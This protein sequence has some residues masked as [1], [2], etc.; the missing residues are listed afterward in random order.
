MGDERMNEEKGV[1][2]FTLIYTSSSPE[3]TQELGQTLGEI[4]Q[5]GDVIC[6]FGDLGA[7][8]TCFAQG[9]AW[10]AGF[11]LHDYISSPTFTLIHEYSGKWP[12]Y[13]LDFYR[14][15]KPEE[16]LDLGYEEYFFGQGIVI[17]EWADRVDGF[18]PPERL[19]V[20][21]RRMNMMQREITITAIG[22]RYIDLMEKLV[23]EV[24]PEG[25]E[26]EQ[27]EDIPYR[28]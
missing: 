15:K 7:G 22:D 23:E 19:E 11:P 18:L 25:E 8:K 17:V 16:L 24:S 26:K 10:G 20:W 13:H 2:S 1:E 14:I 9:V 21:L 12:I 28:A 5:A 6:L 27:E 4:L 3:E